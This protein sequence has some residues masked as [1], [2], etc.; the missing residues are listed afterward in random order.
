MMYSKVVKTDLES[1]VLGVLGSGPMHG[2]GIVRQIKG[3]SALLKVGESQLYPV[4]RRLEERSLITGSWEIQDG[5]PAR[6]VYTLTEEGTRA[7]A[8]RRKE[9]DAYSRHLR[10]LFGLPEAP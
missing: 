3:E 9:F 7:L 6:K 1:L 8:K 2:Y 10:G 4:L 5:R